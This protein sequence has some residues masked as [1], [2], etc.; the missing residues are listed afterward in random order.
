M[1]EIFDKIVEGAG[2]VISEVDKGGQIQSAISGLRH[3]MAEADRKRKVNAIKQ[4]IQDLQAKEAQSINSLSAQVLALYEAGTLKQPELV[5]L[6][7][8]VDEIRAEI[9]EKEAEL[10]QLQPV[11]PAPAEEPQAAA[12]HRCPSCGVAVVAGAAFCQTCGTRLKPEEL[13]APVLFCVH[14]GAQLREGARFCPQCGQ[15]LP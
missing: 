8:G 1:S 10:A 5:S 14:C 9:E 12:G 13:P 2:Q 7:K 3:R 6:C 15:T 11:Q 4:Q